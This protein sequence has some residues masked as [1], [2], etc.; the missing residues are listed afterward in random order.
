MV[1]AVAGAAI[2]APLTVGGESTEKSPKESREERLKVNKNEPIVI[3]SDRM[4]VDQKKNL[5]TYSGRVVAVQ[6]EIRISSA[7][8]K[9][10]FQPQM[11]QIEE[12]VAETQK[13][14]GCRTLVDMFNRHLKAKAP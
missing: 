9:T 13:G 2:F 11:S 12:V 4:E 1:F 14:Y 10:Y 8:L 6:G 7:T 3:T 5:I